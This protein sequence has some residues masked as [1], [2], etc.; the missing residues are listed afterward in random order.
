MRAISWRA[1]AFRRRTCISLSNSPSDRQRSAWPAGLSD[2]N[3]SHAT[4]L[5]WTCS[6]TSHCRT[7][8]ANSPTS[9]LEGVDGAARS[10]SFAT[11]AAADGEVAFFVRK[12]PG[13]KFSSLV[14]DEDVT[15]RTVTIEGP[16]GNFWLRP[17]TAPLLFVAGGSGLA[18]ILAMLRE[19]AN[20]GESRPTTLLFG[21][22]TQRD[23]YAMDE[24]AAIARAVARHIPVRSRAVRGGGRFDLGRRPGL[25]HRHDLQNCCRRAHTPISAAPPR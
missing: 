1:K 14:N 15:G 10:Y 20:A 25:G 17:G 18:P 16:Q 21:A 22:R 3:R 5:A 19:A 6:W 23:L 9:V 8:R 7:G 12:V 4:S 2:G 11:P 13:G 24:I